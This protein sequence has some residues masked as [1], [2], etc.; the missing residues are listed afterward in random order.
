MQSVWV[1]KKKWKPNKKLWGK[2]FKWPQMK[3]MVNF[4]FGMLLVGYT[5]VLA[6]LLRCS[7]VIINQTTKY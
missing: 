1:F 5:D 7:V 6:G 2:M 3:A 4:V